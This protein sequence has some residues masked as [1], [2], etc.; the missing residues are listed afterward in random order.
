MKIIFIL[1]AICLV[2]FVLTIVYRFKRGTYINRK[3][4]NLKEEVFNE[5]GKKNYLFLYQ[6]SVH[7]VSYQV[8]LDA[9]NIA[10]KNGYCVEV[11]SINL[12]KKYEF[13]KYNKIVFFSCVYSGNISPNFA[14]FV[15][16]HKLRGKNILLVMI[17]MMD[18]H[19][20]DYRTLSEHLDSSNK[21]SVIKLNV[22]K[23]NNLEEF[24]KNKI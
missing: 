17:G 20:S 2:I 19:K 9:K 3:W 15:R 24:F 12:T 5:E 14:Y 22:T 16:D 23:P 11:D 10:V 18:F 6:P 1:I 21:L 13:A 8:C 7:N 4:F